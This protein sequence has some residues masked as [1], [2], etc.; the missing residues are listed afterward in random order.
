MASKKRKIKLSKISAL[1]YFKLFFRSF[2]FI[3]ATLLYILHKINGT[4]ESFGGYENNPIILNIIW[5]VFVC[6]MI[7]RFFPSRFESMGC[8]KQ[9]RKNF[10]ETNEKTHDRQSWKTTFAVVLS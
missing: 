3:A 6:E 2:L 8:Q 4:S 7:L 1:H 9:F 10:I 5:I